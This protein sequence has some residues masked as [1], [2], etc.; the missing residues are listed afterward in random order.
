MAITT[1]KIYIISLKS[2][3]LI[4]FCKFK[5]YIFTF[6]HFENKS[7]CLFITITHKYKKLFS[8]SSLYIRSECTQLFFPLLI[9][10]L[11]LYKC[12]LCQN[13]YLLSEYTLNSRGFHSQFSSTLQLNLHLLFFLSNN[14]HRDLKYELLVSFHYYIL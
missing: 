3:H 1:C 10:L 7:R 12:N 13:L 8:Q 14:N 2:C 6:I 5:Q 4:Y 11:E 9:Y